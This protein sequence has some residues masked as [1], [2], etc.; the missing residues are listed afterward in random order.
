M[1]SPTSPT[2]LAD[3]MA[4]LQ[5][6]FILAVIATLLMIAAATKVLSSSYGSPIPR[7]GTNSS[8]PMVPTWIPFVGHAPQ[9]F[10]N[11]DG[12]LGGL[13]GKYPEGVFSL[14][15]CGKLHHFVHKPS[16]ATTLINRPKTTAETVSGGL[17]VSNFGCSKKDQVHHATMANE[18]KS[19]FKHLLSEPGLSDIVS[20]TVRHVKQNI[21]DL[22]TFNSSTTDQ[23]DWERASGVDVVQDSRGEAYVEADLM[24]L[25]RNFIA[26]TA[27]CALYGTDFVENFPDIWQLIWMFDEAF[28]LLASNVP[29]WI[30]WPRLQRAKVVRR[31]ILAYT[32]EFNEAMDKHLR[33]ED[34]GIK[35]QDLD[36]VSALVR[37]RLQ[38]FQDRGL[39]MSARASCDLA[40]CWAMNA[41][42]NQLV[43]W[44]LFEL[45]RDAVLLE[46]VREEIAPYVKVTQP[47]NDFGTAVWVP[48][49]VDLIDI[50][51]LMNKCPLLKAA[52]IETLRVYTGPWTMRRLNED[53]VM[54]DKESTQAF[55][56]Q[57]GTFAHVS[58]EMHQMD[59]AYF[60]DPAEW[61]HE[62]HLKEHTDEKGNKSFVAD[63]GTIRPYGGGP[64]M[65]KGKNF[66]VREMLLYSAMIITFYDMRPP[67]G[68][69]WEIPKTFKPVATRRPKT[70]IKVWIKRREQS[71]VERNEGNGAG[72]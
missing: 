24:E 38:T 17:L 23:T 25:T 37:D 27:N 15:L 31:R 61:H 20:A 66:A 18:S 63:M 55:V 58:Q 65:C 22:V 48:P 68:Q 39:S 57:K 26:K 51:G 6:P 41:N 36:N 34:P 33:G 56:L 10:F 30:P 1:D 11:A 44:M 5:K 46:Q 35:W 70:P 32:Y 54:E 50:D 42:A 7:N 3:V 49:V 64:A 2:A 16:M 13:R 53:V 19:H 28:L 47:V 52:Y 29:A 72:A 21:A 45:Y 14:L 60:P 71:V 67:Q 43:P 8:P 4:Y 9:M 69:S 12:F 59:P 40:L 62:R